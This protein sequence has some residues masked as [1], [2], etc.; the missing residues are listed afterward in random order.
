[1]PGDFMEPRLFLLHNYCRRRRQGYEY[2]GDAETAAEQSGGVFQAGRGERTGGDHE[3]SESDGDAPD[4]D[5]P[6]AGT[7]GSEHDEVD[8]IQQ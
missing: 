3:R 6:G 4:A 8:G 7:N 5:E 1:M 2:A